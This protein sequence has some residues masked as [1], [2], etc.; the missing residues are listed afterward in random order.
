MAERTTFTADGSTGEIRS[1]RVGYFATITGSGT[2][3]LMMRPRLAPW[4]TED[5]WLPAD[6][7]QSSTMARVS[8]GDLNVGGT[9][10]GFDWRVDVVCSGG[11]NSVVVDF[12]PI[13]VGG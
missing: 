4:L 12:F 7:A 6:A 9:T 8:E 1:R 11:G 10:F 2:A 13:E 3:Q 5:T